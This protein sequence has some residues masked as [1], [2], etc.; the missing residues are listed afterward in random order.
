[1]I[2]FDDLVYFIEFKVVELKDRGKALEQIKAKGYAEKFSG[3]EVY[4]I[5]VEFSSQEGNVV[6]FDWEKRL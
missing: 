6:G 1:M 2:R 3:P 5:G 4:L